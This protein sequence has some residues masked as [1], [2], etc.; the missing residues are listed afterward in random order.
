MSQAIQADALPETELS[1][2][3]NAFLGPAALPESETRF[4]MKA[5]GTYAL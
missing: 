4:A 3:E 5:Y 1:I 2:R